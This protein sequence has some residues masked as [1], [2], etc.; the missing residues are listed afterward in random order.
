[1]TR[2]FREPISKLL[3]FGIL[4]R[5][6]SC[7]HAVG[8]TTFTPQGGSEEKGNKNGHLLRVNSAFYPF[9]L[10]SPAIANFEISSTYNFF[11]M[12]K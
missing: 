5:P 12:F 10:V 8:D 3:G 6:T 1:M 7:I 4:R 9:C 11:I 2:I